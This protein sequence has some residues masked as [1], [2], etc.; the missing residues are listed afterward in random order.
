VAKVGVGKVA[1]RG[2]AGECESGT[3]E[4]CAWGLICS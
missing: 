3:S 1:G 4:R 2:A